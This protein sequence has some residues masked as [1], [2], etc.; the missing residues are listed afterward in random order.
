MRKLTYVWLSL[1]MGLISCSTTNVTVE[2]GLY[3]DFDLTD[4]NSYA[5]LDVEVEEAHNA[6][7]ELSVNYLK[8]EI[9]KQ[10]EARGLS[11]DKTNPQLK[12][13]LGIAVEEKEQTR[14]TNLTTDPFMYMGQRNYTWQSQEIVVNKYREGTLTVHFVDAQSNKAAWVGLVS[15]IIPTK[16]E[17]KQA[18]IKAAVQEVFEAIDNKN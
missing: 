8:D 16:Q 4:Y 3:D 6:S 10:M 15:K 12:I 17:K 11:E 2:S 14:E 5:F 18:A 9:N 13:N 1:V 7:F